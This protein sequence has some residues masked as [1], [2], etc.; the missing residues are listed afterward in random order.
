MLHTKR[1][2]HNK[3]NFGQRRLLRSLN[4][5]AINLNSSGSGGNKTSAF[6]TLNGK[7]GHKPVEILRKFWSH[8]TFPYA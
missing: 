1:G 2:T 7:K 6:N 4:F 3:F 8:S 5:T